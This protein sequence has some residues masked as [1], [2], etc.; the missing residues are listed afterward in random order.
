MSHADLVVQTL[1]AVLGVGAVWLSQDR[2]TSRRKYACIVGLLGQPLWLYATWKAGQWGI[3]VLSIIYTFAW[4]KGFQNYWLGPS[5]HDD[6]EKD[7][8]AS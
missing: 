7:T 5:G 2:R 4:L 1:I 3:F 6:D 8:H